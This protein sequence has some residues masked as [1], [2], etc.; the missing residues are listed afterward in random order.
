MALRQGT[1]RDLMWP[2]APWH[3]MYPPGYPAILAV[4]T[5]IGG[6]GFDWLVALQLLLSVATL[7]LTF[8]A[9]RRVLPMAVA[10]GVL[11]A[12]A[13]NPSYVEW[14]G[15][16][17]S[18]PAM[19]LCVALAVWASIAMP[20]GRRRDTVVFLAALAAPF[21]RAAGI[22]VPIAVVAWWLLERRWRAA[23]IA[24]VLSAGIVGPLLWWTLNDPYAVVGSSYAADLVAPI[25]K[26]SGLLASIAERVRV[27]VEYYLTRG[28]PWTLAVPSVE[29]T[30]VDNVLSIVVL[31][32]GLVAGAAASFRRYR[33]GLAIVGA[34]FG[35]LLLWVWQ[36]GRFIV[37]VLPA[38][39]G[40]LFLGVARIA[41]MRG[42]RAAAVAV[43][44]LTLA[45]VAG[46]TPRVAERVRSHARC[47]RGGVLPD[48]AC[49]QEDQTT[50]FRASAFIR[51]SLP[52]RARVL[53][54]KSEPLHYYTGRTTVPYQRFAG[55]TADEFLAE[56]RK[57]GAEYLLLNNL[58]NREAQILAPLLAKRCRAFG[59]VAVYPP[60]TLLLRLRDDSASSGTA[61]AGA[62]DACEAIARYRA[63]SVVRAIEQ[64][65]R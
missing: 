51:D 46:A 58:Q 62:D 35:L 24:A 57:S 25:G 22:V 33:L 15:Q 60:R 43:A 20:P 27:N 47:E 1:Y 6:D 38:I 54:A 13:V 63:D 2:E 3:H 56:M 26:E 31:V 7:A 42:A 14:A 21:M 28:L 64:M 16:V 30:P 40:V 32:A 36:A 9:M 29:G 12:L 41:A 49:V 45:I 5:A 10:L 52:A 18:E 55:L 48:P 34:T 23:A 53:S 44:V 50:F 61:P 8:D 17:A 39:A 4:W 19:A 11:A 59:V 65:Y 37:P